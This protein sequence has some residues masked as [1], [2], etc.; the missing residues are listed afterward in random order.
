M[1]ARHADAVP[2][3]ETP[4]SMTDFTPETR[5]VALL[6]APLQSSAEVHIDL[7]PPLT[8][9]QWHT[10][11]ELIRQS[12]FQSCNE[13]ITS[14][15]AT[16]ARNL[17]ILEPKAQQ[18]RDR[19]DIGDRLDEE[20]DRLTASGIWMM[21]IVDSHYPGHLRGNLPAQAPPVL[22]GCGE[23]GLLDLGGLAVVG[24][25]NASEQDLD[26]AEAIGRHCAEEGI[27]IISGGAKGIDQ[28]AMMG[29]M[30]GGGQT[31]GVLG[32]SLEKQA[33]NPD[34]LCHVETGHL[35]LV[36]PYHPRA[37][38]D[39]GRA[40]GRNK[41]IYAL[42]DWALVISCQAGSGGTWHG[43]NS[44][45][46]SL[47]VPVFVRADDDL[48]KGNKQLLSSGALEFPKPPWSDLAVSLD[49]L[50]SDYRKKALPDA[51]PPGLF[52]D[53]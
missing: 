46:K 7:P 40:M 44:A 18:I 47:P 22:F 43:A 30:E 35:T 26:Y 13:I 31:L 14:D 1:H 12:Q 34:I 25:R 51:D 19:L 20:I 3:A 21:T 15:V 37:F 24:P 29:A 53:Q 5:F 36:S 10:L 42:A 2:I 17:N 9:K 41:I 33:R 52:D 28:Q 45:L 38:F 32:D 11:G 39:V 16:L 48:P 8:S 27:Q 4:I 49:E 23:P 50:S 6:C